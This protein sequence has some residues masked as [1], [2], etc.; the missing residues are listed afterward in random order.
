MFQVSF[1][2]GLKKS[3]VFQESFKG[4]SRKIKG[5]SREFSVGFKSV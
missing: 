4:V 1:K 3:W 5:V 2:G